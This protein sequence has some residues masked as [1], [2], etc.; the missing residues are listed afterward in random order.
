M[1]FK[2]CRGNPYDP[3]CWGARSL[4]LLK[5][6]HCPQ[7]SYANRYREGQGA[8]YALYCSFGRVR[9]RANCCAR[10]VADRPDEAHAAV[11]DVFAR[12]CDLIDGCPGGVVYAYCRM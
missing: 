1:I 3:R 4:F 8:S 11:D 9:D 12:A 10:I 5:Y 7:S 2:L 6:E